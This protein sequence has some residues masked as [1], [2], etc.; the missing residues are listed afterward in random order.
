MV[1][2][3]YLRWNLIRLFKIVEKNSPK[4]KN[5]KISKQGKASNISVLSLFLNFYLFILL[6]FTLVR[7]REVGR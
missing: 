2:K 5:K 1:F 4:L 6:G 7:L 3:G